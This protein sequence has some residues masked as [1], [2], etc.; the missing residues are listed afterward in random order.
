LLVIS[1]FAK[2]NYVDNTRTDQA[3]ITKF[4]EDNWRLGRIGNGSNDASSGSLDNMF[5]FF[6][7]DFRPVILDPKT[8]AVVNQ[9]W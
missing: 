3:S 2:Q 8:G 6:R 9:R 5:N 4:I 1:P 7:P